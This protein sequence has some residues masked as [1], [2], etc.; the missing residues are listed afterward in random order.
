M[1]FTKKVDLLTMFGELDLHHYEKEDGKRCLVLSRTPW[2]TLPLVRIQ[3]ACIFGEAFG[4]VECDCAWQ[5]HAC[6]A[7]IA[8]KG[9]VLVYL[10]QEGRGAGLKAKIAAMALSKA[11]EISNT[12]AFH[13]LKIPV[14]SRDYSLAI[15]AI[16]ELD[17]PKRITTLT[18]N[19]DKIKAL[20][21]GGFQIVRHIKD[22]ENLSRY[23]QKEVPWAGRFSYQHTFSGICKL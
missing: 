11:E 4:S 19:R 18:A 5:L 2:A 22:A 13:A 6:L 20:K 14:D 10:F 17:V 15:E 1:P 7:E 23:L 16:R 12:E 3:S 8:R 21:D 9:G